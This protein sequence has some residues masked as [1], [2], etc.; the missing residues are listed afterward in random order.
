MMMVVAVRFGL[1]STEVS[2]LAIGVL[3]V[4][5]AEPGLSQFSQSRHLQARNCGKSR[6]GPLI[7]INLNIVLMFLWCLPQ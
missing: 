6:P 1:A 5:F 2:E 4:L 3:L 7:H